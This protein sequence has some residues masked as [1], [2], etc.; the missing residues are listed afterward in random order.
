MKRGILNYVIDLAALLLLLLIAATGL[1]QRFVLPPGSG[2]GRGGGPA[3][4]VWGWTRHEWGDVHFW[5]TAALGIVLLLHV[6]L[7]WGW[8]CAL[9]RRIFTRGIDVQL[10]ASWKKNLGGAILLTVVVG[11]LV[12]VVW[13]GK[14]A[15]SERPGTREGQDVGRRQRAGWRQVGSLN[16]EF[17]IRKGRFTN[18]SV[19][20]TDGHPSAPATMC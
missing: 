7:H 6:V 9:S 15:V 13:L 2:G 3:Q 4:V 18:G 17:G 14:S 20:P 1:I 8:V 11:L 16:D 10:I 5:L 19:K 12:G